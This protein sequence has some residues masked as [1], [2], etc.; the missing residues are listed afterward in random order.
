LL[1]ARD[2]S[3]VFS[4]KKNHASVIEGMR[5]SKAGK[6]IFRHNDVAHL[7]ELLA[8]ADPDAHKFAPSRASISWTASA[9]AG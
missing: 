3:I 7:G 9:V 4:D 2:N 1:N 6:R 5:R 8:E